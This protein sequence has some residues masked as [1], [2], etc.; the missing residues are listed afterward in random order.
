MIIAL[1]K[2]RDEMIKLTLPNSME[3]LQS[4]LRNSGI[5]DALE[6]LCFTDYKGDAFRIKLLASDEVWNGFL[7][8][9]GETNTLAEINS[10]AYRLESVREDIQDDLSKNI[11]DGQYKSLPDL[12]QGIEYLQQFSVNYYCP[13]TV[14]TEDE[15]GWELYETDNVVL[16]DH[17]EE[18]KQAVA[19]QNSRNPTMVNY[20]DGEKLKSAVWDIASRGGEV[21]GCI[22]IKLKEP[23]TGSEAAQL[24]DWIIGQNS[25]GWGEVFEQHSIPTED[26]N[27]YVSFWH[28]GDD[29]FLCDD[30]ELADKISEDQG[31]DGLHL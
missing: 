23:M 24:K 12:V 10:A 13:L 21:Y 1:I 30:Q 27:L 28:D 18:L 31:L 19:L 29:Y 25:D 6:Q 22:H 2:T 7:K 11:L 17:Q 9:C 14:K 8:L 20:Y 26:G 15:Q 3:N 4:R 16:A 5:E